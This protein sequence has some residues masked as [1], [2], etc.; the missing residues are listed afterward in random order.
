MSHIYPEIKDFKFIAVC[1]IESSK[2]GAGNFIFLSPPVQK[3]K[4][5]YS[6]DKILVSSKSE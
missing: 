6:I 1:K 3:K 2:T 5:Q 4:W